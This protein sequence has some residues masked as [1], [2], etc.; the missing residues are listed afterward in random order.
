[1]TEATLVAADEIKAY[2]HGKTNDRVFELLTRGGL[3][4]RR[5]VDVGAGEGYFSRLVGEYVKAHDRVPAGEVLRACDLYPDNF[6]YRDV[7][8]DRIDAAGRLPYDDDTFDAAC[9]IE[10]IEHLE[11]QF[12]FIREL[13]RIV[14]PAG[15]I[16]V[17]TP[18]LLNINS[19]VRYLHSGFWLLFDPLP[20]RSHNPVHTGGHIG[21]ITFY[22]LA[23]LFYRAGFTEVNV[24]F[25]R[26]KRSAAFLATVLGPVLALGHAGFKARLRRK[27]NATYRENEKLIAQLNSW[28]MLTS[29]SIV[30]EGIK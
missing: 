24:H 27:E 2:S 26:Q 9:S 1:M 12:H 5:V 18:N 21:P 22:Y 30:M 25:D 29:R 11:D 3:A 6:R 15:R 17:T 28:D 7:V 16:M 20:L 23:Y 8:C 14:K 4:G 10:V 13:Y 19:R